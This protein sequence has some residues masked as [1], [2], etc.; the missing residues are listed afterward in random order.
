MGQPRRWLTDWFMDA[1]PGGCEEPLTFGTVLVPGP[2][3]RHHPPARVAP[4]GVWH[5]FAVSFFWTAF[6]IGFWTGS[7][8]LGGVTVLAVVRGRFI[9]HNYFRGH[10]PRNFMACQ[11][12]HILV[13]AVERVGCSLVVVK[14]RRFPPRGVVTVRTVCC[15]A[16]RGEL[17]GV[18]VLVAAGAQFRCRGEIYVL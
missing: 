2:H 3:T 15:V 17:L 8:L 9:E 16:P 14:L 4:E 10:F 5:A 11:T 6:W 12:R 18:R 1:M 7:P 13:G